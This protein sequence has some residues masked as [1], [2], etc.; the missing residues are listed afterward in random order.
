MGRSQDLQ[1]RS[2][3]SQFVERCLT[4][5]VGESVATVPKRHTHGLRDGLVSLNYP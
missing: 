4:G 3:C 5:E 1:R 2:R